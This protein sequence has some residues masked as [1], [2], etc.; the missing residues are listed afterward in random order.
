MKFFTPGIYSGELSELDKKLWR[1]ARHQRNRSPLYSLT[2]PAGQYVWGNP[3]WE[4]W[5]LL[6]TG[7][8]FALTA[9]AVSGWRFNSGA[10]P[11]WLGVG[12]C[13]LVLPY[14]LSFVDRFTLDTLQRRW[15]YRRGFRWHV[16]E[17]GGGFEDLSHFKL[18]SQRLSVLQSDPVYAASLEFADGYRFFPA[19]LGNRS[20]E[21]VRA[22]AATLSRACGLPVREDLSS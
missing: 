14:Q 3:I 13:V 2:A 18:T 7:T 12:V 1:M 10:W 16:K 17:E 20:L 5:M 9:L 4:V 15:H 6:A 19:V 21:R 8:G 22:R 11:L